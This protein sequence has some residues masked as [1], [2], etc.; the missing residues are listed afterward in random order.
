MTMEIEEFDIRNANEREYRVLNEFSNR[1]RG[2]IVPDDPPI[3]L[4]EAISA[5]R[6]RPAFMSAHRW[7]VWHGGG[8]IVACGD[9]S[10]WLA[11]EN[12]HL[13]QFDLG[14]LPEYRRQGL[15]RQL[16]AKIAGLAQ[17]EQRRLMITRTIDRVP[18][19][20]AFMERIGASKGVAGHLNQLK[21]A[22]LNRDLIR[23]WQARAVERAS[24]FELGLWENEFP[25]A[26]LPAFAHLVDV[27]NTAPRDNLQV[28]DFHLTPQQL[29]ELE[30][31]Y[32]ERGTEVWVMYV[33]EKATGRLAGYTMVLWHPNRPHILVQDDTG[34][35]PEFR[36]RGLGRWLK[37]A[38]LDKVLRE[39]PQVQFVRTGNADS[40]AAMLN[41]NYELGFKPFISDIM[42]QVELEKVV[43]YLG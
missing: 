25:E 13:L 16:L 24:D 5:G 18:A 26:D 7:V 20:A 23:T 15:A 30:R 6:N 14:V 32:I 39:R 43:A 22:E 11:E 36:N 27:M 12:K 9:A 3:P 41:I 35:L 10:F 2:E 1:I 17:R 29:R 34:V 40:N 38:M 19:G 28:E 4:D 37:A 33:R 8:E 31:S 42:W 21:I